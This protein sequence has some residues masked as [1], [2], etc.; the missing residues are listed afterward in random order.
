MAGEC[1]GDGA[2]LASATTAAM[3]AA[4]EEFVV[5]VDDDVESFG[6]RWGASIHI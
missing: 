4:E 1:S 2:G 5:V 3:F 6:G